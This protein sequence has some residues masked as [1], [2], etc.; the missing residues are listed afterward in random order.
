M[1]VTGVA[2]RAGAKI[3]LLGYTMRMRVTS[4]LPAAWAALML[5][6]AAGQPGPPMDI[7]PFG[8]LS[9]WGDAREPMPLPNLAAASAQGRRDVGLEWRDERDVRAVRVRFA[10]AAPVHLKLQY[11]SQTWP[12]P[13]PHMPTIED[14]ADDRWQGAWLTAQIATRCYDRECRY[15]FQPLAPAENPRAGNMPGVPYR[16]ALKISLLADSV[17]PAITALSVFTD[18]V[19]KRVS[20]RVVLGHGE[21]GAVHWAGAV[22]VLNGTLRSAR[23]LG[24]GPADR[25]ESARKWAF[26]TSDS[27]K[28]LLLDLTAA[29]PSL[30]G[31]LD[32]TL[33]TIRALAGQGPRTFTFSV[34]DLKRGPIYVPQ[35]QAYVTDASQA[36]DFRAPLGKGVR[37]RTLIPREPEQTYERASR[38]IPPLDPWQDQYG[39]RIYLP[40]A[41]DSSWQ[42]FA[43]EYGGNVFIRKD[44]TKAMGKERKRLLWAGDRITWNI[45][46]GERPYYREDRKASVSVLEGY[47]PVITQAW[48][49]DGLDYSE[50]AFATLLRGPLSP[51]DPGRDEQTPAILMVQVT[52]QNRTSSARA[53][54]VWVNMQPDEEMRVSAKQLYGE[55]R[56]RAVF[57][58][59][60][61]PAVEAVPTGRGARAAHFSFTVP[62]GGRETLVLKLPFVSD[63]TAADAAELE[64][65]DYAQQRARV[66]AYWKPI[67]DA[68]ARFSTPEAK[69]DMLSRA[70]VWHMRMSATKDPGTGLYM[71]PAAGYDYKVFAN[72]DCFQAL[73]LDAL[74]AHETAAAYFETLLRLQGSK[75]FPG[76]HR[77]ME[78]AIFHGARINEEYDYTASTYG[79]DHPTVLWAL[80]EHYLYARDNDWLSRAWPHMEKAIQWILRQR[81]ATRRT[82][83]DGTKVREYGLLPASS[84]EDNADW[85]NWF[86]IN[87]YAWAALDRTARALEY[88]RHP[89]AARIRR[90]ADAYHAELRAAVIRAT[91]EAPVTQLRDGTYA[92]YVPVEPNQRFRRFGPARAAY[93]TRYGKP[94]MPM[95]RLSATREVLYGPIILLNLGVFDVREPIADWVLDD[96]EDNVTLTSGLGMNVHGPTDDRLWFS[97]GGMVFQANLQNPILV[98]LKRHEV[99]AAIRSMYNNFI[100]CL[101]PDANAF[102]EEYRQWRHASGPFYKVPDEAKFVNR[103]RDALV[104]EDGDA[105]YLASG[106]PRRW[107]GSKEGIRVDGIATWFG[108]VSY[109]MR[110]GD[111]PGTVH[112]SVQLPTRNPPKTVWLVA[113]TPERRIANVTIN[114]RPWNRI[115]AAREAIELPQDALRLEVVIRYR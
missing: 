36:D 40:L 78:D 114:G 43:F 8:V 2:G 60:N 26:V 49:S 92:P 100:A 51:D 39:A 77:G 27:R 12:A 62:A 76:L 74:G 48:Q 96:W 10:A 108:P 30:P 72:E 115:D 29:A 20:V 104:L 64:R 32:S 109:T 95:L 1:F 105:L 98:Y 46:T 18:S 15:T 45:G 24:F 17:L 59:V 7:A 41:A 86:S 11:W 21:S 47:L 5:S 99:P 107:L 42:K 35:V 87:G 83:P 88:V 106:V 84:L 93:Y 58:T 9:T 103:V 23:P 50:E 55:G 67:V 52:A 4:L 80:A 3:S 71:A 102:T 81:E 97:Q 82:E 75:S 110:A 91:E 85:A 6:G 28:G 68:S 113:R 33:V 34:D 31:S 70:V 56:L 14:P 57:E 90:E 65:L 101:Y 66:L 13:V 22:E 79:L 37:I 111:E 16:R 63:L 54:H 112:A 25:F 94:G 89:E 53:G 73:L 38:E 44:G 69:L 19:E 61:P